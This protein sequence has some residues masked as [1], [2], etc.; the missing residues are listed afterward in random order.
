MSATFYDRLGL[1]SSA[2]NE[3]IKKAYRNLALKW[4]PDKNIDNRKECLERF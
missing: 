4:H 3:Q 2:T 1:P